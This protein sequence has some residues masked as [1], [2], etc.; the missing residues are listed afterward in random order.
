MSYVAEANIVTSCDGRGLGL[1]VH[2]IVDLA[3]TR[4]GECAQLSLLVSF[5]GHALL[6]LR[7]KEEPLSSI[8]EVLACLELGRRGRMSSLECMAFRQALGK[9]ETYCSYLHPVHVI[10]RQM[11]VSNH[12]AFGLLRRR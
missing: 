8:S 2:H 3:S 12:I 6:V 10:C 9:Y 7:D 1:R 4:G 11:D 5:R